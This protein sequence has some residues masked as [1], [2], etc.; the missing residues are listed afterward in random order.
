MVKKVEE[1]KK[2]PIK[3]YIILAIIFICGIGITLYLC[4]WYRVYDDY[5]RQTPVIRGTLSEITTEELEHY[6]LENPTAVFYMCTSEDIVCRS[7]E[8]D[9][10][11]YIEKEDLFNDIVYINL[12]NID[13]QSFVDNFNNR[14]NYKIKLTSNYPALVIFDEGKVSGI[15]QGDE[16]EKLTVSKTKQ[17]IEM[18]NIGE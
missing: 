9:F 6:V 10:K 2:I 12:S 7:Y 1:E 3:N 4:D 11:K 14:Y 17:F 13:I 8:K 16:E 18:N 15:I 5:Q